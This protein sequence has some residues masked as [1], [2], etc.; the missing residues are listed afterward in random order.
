MPVDKIGLGVLVRRGSFDVVDHDHI[1]LLV[2]RFELQP[3]LFL[4]GRK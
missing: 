1:N 3:K 4:H 2:L